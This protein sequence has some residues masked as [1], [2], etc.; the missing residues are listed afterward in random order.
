MANLLELFDEWK[1]KQAPEILEEFNKKQAEM[2][3]ER[4]FLELKVKNLNRELGESSQSEYVLIEKNQC[5]YIILKEKEKND[6][7]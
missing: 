1:N 3:D 7:I 6:G 5:L 2:E 4:K